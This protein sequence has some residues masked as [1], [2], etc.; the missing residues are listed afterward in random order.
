[1]NR[2]VL[3]ALLAHT[4]ASASA[5]AQ[6][7]TT[8]R[9]VPLAEAVLLAQRNAPAAVMARGTLRTSAAGVRS[10]Y[11]AF[12][13]A[14]S[15][16]AGAT[17]QNGDRFSPQGQL[18]PFTGDPWQ[19]NDGLNA[20]LELFSGL[21][22]FN[23]LRAARRDV[24][25]ADAGETATKYRVALDVK[26]Q[27]FN[28]LAAR[29]SEAAA[30]AQ[31]A[32]AEQ[33]LRA[34]AAR[35]AAGAATKSDSLRARIQVGSATLAR[36]TAQ[37]DL[38]VANASLT[39]L[40]GVNYTV[41]AQVEDTATIASI[42]V[43]SSQLS[44]LAVEGPAVRQAEAALGAARA[45]ARAA[46]APYLPTV[47]LNYNR[48][49]NGSDRRFGLGDD[50]YAYS[51]TLRLALNFPIFN[52]FTREEQVVRTKV[53]EDNAAATLRDAR[54]LAEQQLTQFVGSLRLAEERVRIQLS[55]IAAAEEDLRV[56]EQRYALGASTQLDVLTSQTQLNQARAALIQAR[57]DARVA[58][59]QIE[60][61]IGRD[62][63]R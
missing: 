39:R 52:Q 44:R 7:D 61:L 58:A 13:P 14:L 59:A 35:V 19:Y 54:L 49:G 17:N 36:S 27:Y 5:H 23:E 31:L 28:V 20:S 55:T 43:D 33:Q 21:R 22:R 24:D 42:S 50:R 11:G 9:P 46:V 25:A 63:S 18:V 6:S 15:V 47:T 34:S 16:S 4:L 40:L 37:N 51:S 41:T 45:T 53:A 10:A 62:L 29:E 48:G 12:M 2:F 1:M 8:A 57:L 3:S 60:A 56:Q 26:Q 32:Q 38:R 30:R